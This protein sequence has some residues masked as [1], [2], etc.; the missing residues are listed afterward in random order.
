VTPRQWSAEVYAHYVD[1]HKCAGCGRYVCAGKHTKVL[2][3]IVRLGRDGM[4]SNRYHTT[5][6]YC[7]LCAPVRRLGGFV[8]LFSCF[9]R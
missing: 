1:A 8:G 7:A 6:R 3:E 9:F 4:R 2:D 5:L